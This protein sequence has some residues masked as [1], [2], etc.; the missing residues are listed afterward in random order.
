MRR[1]FLLLIIWL[2]L[3]ATAFS[4]NPLQETVYLKNGSV[5]KG[6]IV[7]QV[8]NHSI[9]IQTAD[10]SI[11]VY[12]MEEVEK[13][14]K[15]A[16]YS[17]PYRNTSYLK[18]HYDIT[19]YRGFVDLGYTIGLGDFGIGRIEATTSHGYQFN[20]HFFFG[21]G[22]GIHY[23]CTDGAEDIVV[24]LFLDFRGNFTK[25]AIV[26]FGGIK[27]G[28]SFVATESFEDFGAYLAP[29]IGVKFMMSK[30]AA[31]NLSLGYT[32]QFAE[33]YD[34]YYTSTENT[35]GLS[36]KAGFEF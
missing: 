29:A 22:S 20:P 17:D 10:G 3:N 32:F 4:Q 21:A 16:T 27:A 34:Y 13:M 18:K 30:R 11:F 2:S 9:K 26:P 28:Y 33:V 15:E 31:F 5:I 24:P 36:F 12:K 35:G 25:G 23:Y 19:G 6:T 8:P 14:T 7:E 1:I